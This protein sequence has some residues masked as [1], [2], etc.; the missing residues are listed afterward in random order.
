MLSYAILDFSER[1]GAESYSA[2][3]ANSSNAYI[4]WYCI[5]LCCIV[6]CL[7]ICCMAWSPPQGLHGNA[8]D[9]A[10]VSVGKQVLDL[11]VE[12]KQTSIHIS[13]NYCAIVGT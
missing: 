10:E 11:G 1:L 8:F 3:R 4:S 13:A 5:V 9:S 7:G 2:A 6:L 12:L